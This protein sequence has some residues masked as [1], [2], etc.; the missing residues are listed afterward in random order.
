MTSKSQWSWSDGWDKTKE[1]ERKVEA[2]DAAEQ[3]GRDVSALHQANVKLRDVENKFKAVT[4]KEI[5][6]RR[7]VEEKLEMLRE[8][9]RKENVDDENVEKQLR[10]VDKMLEWML[11][12]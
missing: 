10:D 11:K 6:K 1:W 12:N 3:L 4:V 7:N 9:G 8:L 2:A 5:E